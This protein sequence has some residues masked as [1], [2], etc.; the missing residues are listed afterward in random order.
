MESGICIIAAVGQNLGIGNNNR[1]PWALRGDMA[2]FRQMTSGRPIISGRNTFESIVGPRQGQLLDRGRTHVVIT[3]DRSWSREG[4]V[5]AHSMNEALEKAHAIHRFPFVIGGERVYTEA[6]PHAFTLYLTLVDS[7]P[8][9]DTYF[10]QYQ[11]T[12]AQVWRGKD[13]FEEGGIVY[14]WSEWRRK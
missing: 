14:C 9:A 10:P 5:V 4:V 1:L 6:L 3:T 11:D 13:A 2:Y 12:F 8:K 7:Y